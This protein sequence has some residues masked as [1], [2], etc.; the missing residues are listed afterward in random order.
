M[1][2]KLARL[3]VGYRSLLRVL[4]TSISIACF[5]DI[6]QEIGIENPLQL[7]SFI[8]RGY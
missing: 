2:E 4:K 7:R 3:L 1:P 6:D 8:S 5:I